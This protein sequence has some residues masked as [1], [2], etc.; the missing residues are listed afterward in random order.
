MTT[1]FFYKNLFASLTLITIAACNGNKPN[2]HIEPEPTFTKHLGIWSAPAYG[3]IIQY[4]ESNGQFLMNTYYVTSVSCLLAEE[5]DLLSPQEISATIKINANESQLELIDTEQFLTPGIVYDRIDNLPQ[6]CLSEL[7]P[8]A[9][10]EGYAF[11]PERDFQIFWNS[12]NEYYHD[13]TLSDTNWEEVYALA[14]VELPDVTT[15]EDLF[16]L[17]SA[18]YEPLE[19][20]H[21]LILH[22]DLSN[23]VFELLSSGETENFYSTSHKLNLEDKL[24]LEY[25]ENNGL[26]LPLTEAQQSDSASYIEDNTDLITD[27]VLSYADQDSIEVAADDSI[28]WFKTE[29]NI[30]YLII[31]S[32]SDYSDSPIDGQVDVAV[33]NE[34]IDQV[35]QDL[36]DTRGLI[37]DIRTNGGGSDEISMI[38][39][40]RFVNTLTHVYSKQA[41]LGATRTPLVD[42]NISPAGNI[43]YQAPIVLLTSNT[44][45]SAAEVFGLSMRNLTN[46]TLMG[47]SSAGEFS[48]ILA[49]RV[50]SNIAFGFSNE[51]YLSPNNEWFERMGIPVD[52]EVPFATQQQRDEERD[53][54]LEQ[55]ILLLNH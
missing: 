30:G 8:L 3:E 35:M 23:G 36:Q 22:G 29:G 19:D 21:N 39:A 40:S 51:Y 1:N 7:Y 26:Q 11:N 13:F 17:F 41:R 31:T 45:A 44:T 18:M 37:I 4:T 10:N 53:Y 15:E 42:V 20:G 46:V 43:Q 54:G 24:L 32:M 28:A 27:I 47:E 2:S 6:N 16:D 12:L 5:N 14:Q 33:A 9:H 34:V 48:D 49:H 50:T 38:F 55:A 25:I 52:I